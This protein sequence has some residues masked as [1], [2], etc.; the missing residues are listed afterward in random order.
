MAT[1]ALRLG[2]MRQLVPMIGRDDSVTVP[3]RSAR[4]SSALPV[5]FCR[6]CP[7]LPPSRPP[8]APPTLAA[9][10]PICPVTRSVPLSV[11]ETVSAS[12]R[13]ATAIGPRASVQ[14]ISALLSSSVSGL[15]RLPARSRGACCSIVSRMAVS[16][17][18]IGAV[19]FDTRVAGRSGAS[20]ASVGG[21]LA[22]RGNKASNPHRAPAN[23]TT[24]MSAPAAIRPT[25]N[26]T[27][28][29]RTTASMWRPRTIR[30]R[31]H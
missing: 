13:P 10:A 29:L 17:T 26:S 30:S 11:V 31:T 23:E 15:S 7:I 14:P 27:S 6:P 8:S 2:S 1:W 24:R 4:W 9:W 20:A 18:A 22:P 21:R 16:A 25:P 28:A 5:R 12:V 19:T 3:R